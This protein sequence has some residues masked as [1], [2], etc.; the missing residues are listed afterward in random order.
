MLL[1]R[2]DKNVQNF[3]NDHQ[4]QFNC[5]IFCCDNLTYDEH[6]FNDVNQQVQCYGK[7]CLRI[8]LENITILNFVVEVNMEFITTEKHILWGLK[9]ILNLKLKKK[10]MMFLNIN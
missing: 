3:I 9:I 4:G 1:T 10:H 6:A 7:I 5:Q 2:N 8:T